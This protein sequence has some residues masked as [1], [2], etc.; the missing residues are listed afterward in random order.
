[1]C[2]ADARHTS[3]DFLLTEKEIVLSIIL[4]THPLDPYYKTT[5]ERCVHSSAADGHPL[6]LAAHGAVVR[7]VGLRTRERREL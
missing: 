3:F 6:K 1:V 7:F 4:L 2:R 5:T